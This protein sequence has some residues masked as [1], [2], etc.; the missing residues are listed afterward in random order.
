MSFFS[1]TLFVVV[2]TTVF[3]SSI[4]CVT[5]MDHSLLRALD[6]DNNLNARYPRLR[7]LKGGGGGDGALGGVFD[8][9]PSVQEMIEIGLVVV[10]GLFIY[11]KYQ[12]SR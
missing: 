3:M 5:A 8:V 7:T 1:K 6:S 9:L 10:I 11:K 2:M 4:Q 12:Q